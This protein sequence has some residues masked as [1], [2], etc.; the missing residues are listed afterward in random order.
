MVNNIK[1][2]KHGAY[3]THQDFEFASRAFLM[4]WL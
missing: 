2:F 4:D 1:N 3:K